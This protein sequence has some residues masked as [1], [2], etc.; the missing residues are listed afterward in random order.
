[1]RRI[2][3]NSFF[4]EIFVFHDTNIAFYVLEDQESLLRS[5]IRF[6]KFR[7]KSFKRK[8]ISLLDPFQFHS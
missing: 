3:N 2:G 1:M 6:F 7:L 4:F 8:K 5:E